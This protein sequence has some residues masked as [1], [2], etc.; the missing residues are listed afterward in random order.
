V[1]DAKDAVHRETVT[2]GAGFPQVERQWKAP[3]AL[4]SWAHLRVGRS[5]I[6]RALAHERCDPFMIPLYGFY[7]E[8]RLGHFNWTF[9]R[10]K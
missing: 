7:R 10:K 2:A 9:L 5:Q 3:L 8:N 4:R 1:L 6:H